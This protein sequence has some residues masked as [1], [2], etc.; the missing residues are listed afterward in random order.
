[1]AKVYAI[2]CYRRDKQTGKQKEYMANSAVWRKRDDALAEVRRQI[3]DRNY[4]NVT[5]TNIRTG[6]ETV[7]GYRY[8]CKDENVEYIVFEWPV[9]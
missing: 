5:S 6:K 9:Y 3:G 4:E 1:M 8:E 2:T 7:L